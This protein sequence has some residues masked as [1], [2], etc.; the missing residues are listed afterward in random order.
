MA[1]LACA[2]FIIAAL[3]TGTAR[4]EGPKPSDPEQMIREGAQRILE[5]VRQFIERIPQYAVPEV[6]PNGDIII[7]KLPR[8]TTPGWPESGQKPGADGSLRT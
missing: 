6:M 5:G 2:V 1:K 3:A 7:R 8:G 4:A